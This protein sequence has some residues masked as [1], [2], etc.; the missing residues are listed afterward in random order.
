MN[1]DHFFSDRWDRWDWAFFLGGCAIV[2]GLFA[3]G[4]ETL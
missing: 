1:R 3:Y 4:M 2:V